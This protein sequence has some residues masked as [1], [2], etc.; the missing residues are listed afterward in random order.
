MIVPLYSALVRLHL[1]S[2]VQFWLPHCKRDTEVLERVQ[3]RAMRLE[4]GLEHKSDEEQLRELGVFSLER[5]KL[6]GPYC[7]LQLSGRRLQAGGGRSLL[8][9]DK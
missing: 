8:P 9:G 1:E 7:S 2:C 5:W 3:R 4:K 6:R